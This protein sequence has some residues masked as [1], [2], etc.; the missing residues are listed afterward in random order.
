MITE[1]NL[2]SLELFRQVLLCDYRT[3][4]FLQLLRLGKKCEQ[5][6]A[7][8][9]TE[10]F[11]EF[12][13]VFWVEELPNQHCFGINSVILLCAMCVWQ[14]RTGSAQTGV[15]VTFPIL[16]AIC[17]Y[18]LLYIV[19]GQGRKRRKAKISKKGEIPSSL[20]HTNPFQNYPKFQANLRL[21]RGLLGTGPPHLKLKSASPSPSQ[22][23]FGIDSTS[24][25]HWFDI[26]F[27]I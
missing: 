10:L 8:S 3:E 27:L 14:L 17:S 7:E 26:D 9:H 16:S 5:R 11:W 1:P 19:H 2:I 15:R 22:G 18:L 13:S 6:I 20:V 21:V 4:M 12:C 23:R 25:R 24:I